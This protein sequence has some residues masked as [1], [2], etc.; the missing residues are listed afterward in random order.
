MAVALAMVSCSND[1]FDSGVSMADSAVEFT[2]S[3][4]GATGTRAISDGL[5]ADIVYAVAFLDGQYVA[6]TSSPVSE[7]K[8][9]V[10]FVLAKGQTYDFAFWAQDSDCK[11]YLFDKEKATI[12]IDYDVPAN[13]ESRD[14]FFAYRTFHIEGEATHEVTLKRPFA[15]LNLGDMYYDKS[16]AA[17]ITV[18]ASTVTVSEVATTLNLLDGTIGGIQ[19]DVTFEVADRPADEKLVVKET[20]Y[21]WLSMNYLLV[22]DET[23]GEFSSTANVTFTLKTNSKD[24]TLTSDNTP[25]R[26]NWRTNILT[27]LVSN[28]TFNIIIDQKFEGDLE[29]DDVF[30]KVAEGVKYDKIADAFVIESAEGLQWLSVES[31]K[32]G[33]QLHE[34]IKG[35]DGNAIGYFINQTIVLDGDI[36]MANIKNWTPMNGG[37]WKAF[38]G[39][40]D[41]NGYTIRNLTSK[42]ADAGLFGYAIGGVIKNVNMENVTIEATT[43]AGAIAGYAYSQSIENCHV[44]GANIKAMAAAVDSDAVEAGFAGGIVGYLTVEGADEYI[45]DCSVS[46]AQITAN[47]EVGG[48]I[49]RAWA[50]TG[51]INMAGNAVI[52]SDIILNALDVNFCGDFAGVVAGRV[53]ENNDAKVNI[54]DVTET[55]VT[56]NVLEIDEN[57]T[58]EVGNGALAAIAKLDNENVETVVFT[59]DI[60]GDASKGGYDKSGIVHTNGATIDGGGKTLN[61]EDANGTWD[62]ALYTRGGTIKNLT[63]TGA[64]RGIFTD[65]LKEKLIIDN[66]VVAPSAYTISADISAS[67][68]VGPGFEATNS[69]FRGWTSYSKP[70]GLASF[71]NCRF[72][73]GVY[74][75]LRPYSD[76]VLTD[77]VFEAG[78][79]LDTRFAEVTLINCK[80]G[81]TV[82]TAE[83]ITTLLGDA[84]ANAKVQ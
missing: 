79:P 69:T 67:A 24:I 77:C 53:R 58:V 65:G 29:V 50:Y 30:T 10:N 63:I 55:D 28:Q 3:F 64:F 70:I 44:N 60:E 66:C 41:G 61:V 12:T 39:T 13:D 52:S 72:E 23:T 78:F 2:L 45:N 51:D 56:V 40:F 42:A 81:E 11:S 1:D 5:S 59:E 25:L 8:A 43:T 4:D 20:N 26:R 75:M 62:C 32:D 71:T 34:L 37:F 9:T 18:P 36:D 82:I 47:A 68:P 19:N 73:A 84:A 7:R 38:G 49:G 48:I 76:T 57:G 80:V 15:Q 33:E 17:G 74:A 21:E 83:N 54:A 22:A 31:N 27:S 14:A 16:T 6:D 46:N 35:N